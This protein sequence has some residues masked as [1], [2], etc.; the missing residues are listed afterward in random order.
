MEAGPAAG[1]PEAANHSRWGCGVV[2]VLEDMQ[3]LLEMLPEAE[4]LY[5]F[6]LISVVLK[7]INI[8]HNILILSLSPLF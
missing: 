3:S 2:G 5:L 7:Y 1:G 6:T 4:I 8:L